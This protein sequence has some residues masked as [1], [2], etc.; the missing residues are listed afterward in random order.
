MEI[1]YQ[2]PRSIACKFSSL[3]ISVNK[4]SK[5]KSGLT[6][7][8]FLRTFP[9]RVGSWWEEKGGAVEEDQK[10][11]AGAGEY[12][13]DGVHIRG[14]SDAIT[15][16]GAD[17]QAASYLIDAED[18]RILVCA[19]L[20][21]KAQ[22]KA[23]VAAVD[24]ADVL[25]VFCDEEKELQLTATEVAGA[26]ASLGVRRL[27]MVGDNEKLQKKIASEIGSSEPATT[28]CV[29]K[30]KQLAESGVTALSLK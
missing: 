2:S 15:Y 14:Y 12:E 7:N 30:K 1:H 25:V 27:V 3:I 4:P 21:S 20:S 8:V 16:D 5:I 26:A 6:P 11:F 17:L 29:I 19:P 28:K 13:K 10:V 18:I 9:I 22:L 24:R 23:L